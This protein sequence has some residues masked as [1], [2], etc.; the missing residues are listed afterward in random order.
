MD[1]NPKLHAP[2]GSET[3]LPEWLTVDWEQL[4]QTAGQAYLCA[5]VKNK[6][7]DQMAVTLDPEY[8]DYKYCQW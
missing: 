3:G 7:H 5:A 4:T 6:Y 2:E 1:H 8:Y